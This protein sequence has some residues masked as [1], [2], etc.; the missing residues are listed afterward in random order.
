MTAAIEFRHVTR[1]FGRRTVLRDVSFRVEPGEIF[2]FLGPN[3]AGKSTSIR[4]ILGLTTPSRGQVLLFGKDVTKHRSEALEGVGALVDGPA[5]H[6]GLTALEN[7]RVFG[8]L[9][10]TRDTLRLLALLAKVGLAE[11]ANDRVRTFS[12]GMRVRLGI[13]LAL[14]RRPRLLVLDEPTDGLD[15]HGVHGVRTL[16]RELQKLGVTIF[17]S[18]HLLSEIEAVC[19]R[20]AI[21]VSGTLRAQGTIA[22]L[23]KGGSLE[24][25]FL[26]LTRDEERRDRMDARAEEPLASP[27]RGGFRSAFSSEVF[28]LRKNRSNLFVLPVLALATG[29]LAWR[30]ESASGIARIVERN[31][32]T[33]LGGAMGTSAFLLAVLA[34]LLGASSIAS[35]SH[36][37]TLRSALSLPIGKSAF[38]LGKLAAL[39]AWLF[40]LYV[41]ALGTA[42]GIAIAQG[43]FLSPLTTEELASP[44]KVEA[45]GLPA[46]W[47]STLVACC[48]TYLGILACCGLGTLISTFSRKA[49]EAIIWAALAFVACFVLDAFLEYRPERSYQFFAYLESPWNHVRELSEK[50]AGHSWFW[51]NNAVPD[52]T[53]DALLDRR[54]ASYLA[55]TVPTLQAAL[56]GTLVW[57]AFWRRDVRA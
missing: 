7:L 35:E 52:H 14:L 3:G 54:R 12:Y 44:P 19:D 31:G 29:L 56:L 24:E 50:R 15:P 8:R 9:T 49:S 27:E 17:L 55:I 33:D 13:A 46:L 43:G 38:V 1:R 45:Y 32:F 10:G 23:T 47:S 18:S 42:T 26:E 51:G 2:G 37:G 40:L 20:V 16:L 22:E 36:D 53:G 48:S 4:M 41:V 28:K 21:L 57:I 11:R 34:L 5:L 39:A 6:D 25:R 30:F